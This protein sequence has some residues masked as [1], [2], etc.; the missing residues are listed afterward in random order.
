MTKLKRASHSL[1]AGLR[2][3]VVHIIISS[4]LFVLVC[5]E[6]RLTDLQEVLNKLEPFK[7]QRLGLLFVG[8]VT[9]FGL[10]TKFKPK[11]RIVFLKEVDT[12]PPQKRHDL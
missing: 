7:V 11:R 2:A 4:P 6:E 5:A 9:L 3:Y 1:V 12:W 10:R 8:L